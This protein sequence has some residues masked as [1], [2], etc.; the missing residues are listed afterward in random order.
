MPPNILSKMPSKMPKIYKRIYKRIHK[1]KKINAK[2][3]K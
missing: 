3:K 2:G 1:K